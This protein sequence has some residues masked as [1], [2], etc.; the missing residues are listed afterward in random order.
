MFKQVSE[1]F[2]RDIVNGLSSNKAATGK[3]QLK[4]LKECNFSSHFITNYINEAI[5]NNKFPLKLNL[6]LKIDSLK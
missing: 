6:S 5:K 3:I 1:E 4:I 2:V